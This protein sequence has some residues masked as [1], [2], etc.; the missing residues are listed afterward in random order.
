M[1]DL[2]VA[3]KSAYFLQAFRRIGLV[4][5]GGS[6]YLL[7]RMIGRA[8]AMEMALLGDKIPA[9]TALAWGLVNRV[10]EDADLLSTAR[11]LAAAL[12]SGPRSLGLIRQLIWDGEDNDWELQ[13][14]EERRAQAIAGAS[15]DFA[16]GVRA[17]LDKRP[18]NFTGG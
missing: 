1:G 7:P 8:R 5:D 9:E 2:I 17:F 4:P 3:G 13:L 12:A 14:Q 6:T 16:E 11:G 10:T 15:S 18:P